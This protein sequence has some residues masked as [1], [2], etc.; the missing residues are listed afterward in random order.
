MQ[1]VPF[2]NMSRMDPEIKSDPWYTYRQTTPTVDPGS[3]RWWME[4]GEPSEESGE[5][6]M[7]VE[8]RHVGTEQDE[9]EEVKMEVDDKDVGID[10]VAGEEDDSASGEKMSE[11]ARGKQRQTKTGSGKRKAEEQSQPEEPASKRKRMTRRDKAAPVGGD[12]VDGP[13]P[14]CVRTGQ[15]CEQSAPGAAC[16][17]CRK[18]KLKCPRCTN[19]RG[20]KA[21]D[22]APAI[23]AERQ[24]SAT[25]ARSRRAV[26]TA[27]FRSTGNASLTTT[28]A[29]PSLTT[30]PAPTTKPTSSRATTPAK[31]HLTTDTQ[32]VRSVTDDLEDNMFEFVAPV[33]PRIPCMTQNIRVD[34]RDRMVSTPDEPQP[35]SKPKRRS[36]RIDATAGKNAKTVVAEGGKQKRGMSMLPVPCRSQK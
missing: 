27:G 3:P 2:E 31:S 32:S 1:P 7:R 26:S 35:P 19:R 13:C 14:R 16:L 33:K 11:K 25:P 23:K 28:P 34:P 8:E 24:A 21:K 17:A 4:T 22:E 36:T 30:T 18:S 10:T 5:G 20:G 15:V 9:V 6:S 29:P 12:Y